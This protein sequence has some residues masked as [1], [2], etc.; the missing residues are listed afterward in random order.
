MSWEKT[1][2]KKR[3]L[4]FATE[5]ELG[6]NNF[7][8][9]KLVNNWLLEQPRCSLSTAPC[10]DCTG[11]ADPSAQTP[12]LCR[13]GC[14]AR[15]GRSSPGNLEFRAHL[16]GSP[17]SASVSGACGS[18]QSWAPRNCCWHKWS[19][20]KRAGCSATTAKRTE[21]HEIPT[22]MSR[23]QKKL[24]QHDFSIA[25]PLLNFYN[26]LSLTLYPR[27]FCPTAPTKP[28]PGSRGTSSSLG[29]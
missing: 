17:C 6:L 2:D 9:R 28:S 7:P 18:G 15:E 21:I 5:M 12:R 10:S 16:P 19:P 13:R 8:V 25:F 14:R 3:Q 4:T 24:K 27:L 1:T 23:K 26:L 22:R 20:R 29:L 11:S